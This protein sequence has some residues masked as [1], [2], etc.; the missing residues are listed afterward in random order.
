MTKTADTQASDEE[1]QRR[2]VS[3]DSTP[4]VMTGRQKNI[5]LQNGGYRV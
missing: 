3:D 4:F 1:G 2:A 5:S